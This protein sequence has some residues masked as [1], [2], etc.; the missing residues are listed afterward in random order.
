VYRG[1]QS[2]IELATWINDT[3]SLS[4][5]G[6]DFLV[7]LLD[8]VALLEANGDTWCHDE[9]V[10]GDTGGGKEK[11]QGGEAQRRGGVRRKPNRA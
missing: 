5:G 2:S 8:G 6:T 3:Y 11:E 10:V 1:G 7:Q 4:A 9:D